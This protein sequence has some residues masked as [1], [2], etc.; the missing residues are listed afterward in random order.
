MRQ[1]CNLTGSPMENPDEYAAALDL[2]VALHE[3]QRRSASDPI[4]PS[5]DDGLVS[6]GAARSLGEPPVVGLI[7]LVVDLLARYETLSA[8]NSHGFESVAP[9]EHLELLRRL[10][11]LRTTGA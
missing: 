2:I 5:I 3:A 1:G 6:G 10:H 4:A 8:R 7:L 11:A 9:V